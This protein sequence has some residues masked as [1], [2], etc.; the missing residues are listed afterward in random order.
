MAA[1]AALP[2]APRT[3]AASHADDEAYWAGIAAQYDVDRSVVQLENAY[4]GVM[5]RPVMAEYLRQVERVNRQSSA[6]A[7]RAFYQDF[8]D[9]RAR[10]AGALGVSPDEIAITRNATEALTGL[11][12]QYNRLWPGD[13]VL[14][15][16]LDYDSMRS[17]F[18]ALVKQRGVTLVRIDLPE[19]A[20]YQG[21]IDAYAQAMAANPKL[22]LMLLT[23]LSHRTG[24]VLPV[25]EIV[26]M[27]RARGIDTI[28]DAAHS[29]GQ[30]DFTLPDLDADFVGLNVHKWIGAPLG[31]GLMY[32]RKSRIADIDPDPA[33]DSGH[34]E[35]I[36]ARVHTGTA[37]FAAQLTVPAALDFHLGIGGAAKAKRL[38]ALRDGWAEELRGLDGLEVLT[39]SDQRLHGA[40]TSFRIRGLTSVKDNI[41]VTQALMERHR[42]FTVHRPGVAKGACV[43]VTPALFTK[44]GE[45]DAFKV[46]L[47]DIV[48][49]MARPA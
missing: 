34:P 6:Y 3:V 29:W 21:L 7:R 20:T 24:L 27:A 1:A 14:I 26:A 37:D 30:I 15:A 16:D 10:L 23:H 38:R 47:R 39:P 28:V 42:V 18:E 49:K 8:A 36:I 2:L 19:P 22:R 46:A 13:A 32:I 43:R 48:P 4:W 31:V 9:V 12:G 25:R 17:A 41:G 5:A 44:P 11:I 35:S 45:I 40:I 33:D